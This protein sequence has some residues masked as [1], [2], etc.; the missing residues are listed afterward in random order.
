MWS[1]CVDK[2]VASDQSESAERQKFLKQKTKLMSMMIQR[3][4]VTS[5]VITSQTEQINRRTACHT[6][7]RMH[8]DDNGFMHMQQSPIDRL[9][10]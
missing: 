2:K 1:P 5:R 4:N 8:Y 9:C 6:E 7:R 10:K 3:P